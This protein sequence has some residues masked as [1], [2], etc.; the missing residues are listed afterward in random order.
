LSASKR[1]QERR[2]RA[3]QEKQGK[4]MADV[5]RS[6]LDEAAYRNFKK[7]VHRFDAHEIPFD[8]PAGIVARV[9]RLLESA[10]NL[11]EE[12]RRTVLDG[13]VKI[14]LQNAG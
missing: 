6:V 2:E 5:I 9:E 11:T 13:F 8:G 14:I 4:E 12:K 3:R 1:E 10:P 7:D